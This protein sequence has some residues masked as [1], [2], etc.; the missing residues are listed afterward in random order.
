MLNP[1]RTTQKGFPA[2]KIAAFHTLLLSPAAASR[3]LCVF[4]RSAARRRENVYA[5]LHPPPQAAVLGNP[6]GG[7]RA[8][9]AGRVGLAPAPE[10][11]RPGGGEVQAAEGESAACS[12][13][14]FP[15]AL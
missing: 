9:A 7:E 5:V 10:P 12:W 14:A 11:Q 1:T 3:V 4:P 8:Q 6:P 13:P 15:P 2:L